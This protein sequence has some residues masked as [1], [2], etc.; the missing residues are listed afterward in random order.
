[1]PPAP[2][3]TRPFP[4]SRPNKT[5]WARPTPSR[6]WATL[7]RHLGNLDAAR[8]H[9]DAALPLYQGRT[10]PPRAPANTLQSLGELESHLGNLDAARAHYDAA[11]PLY[12]RPNVPGAWAR[13]TSSRS[14]GD[15][16]S[17]PRQ[18]RCRPRPLRRGSSPLCKA[19]QYRLGTG[20]HP[21][22]SGRPGAPPRQRR[23]RPRHPL[24][25]RPF[26]SSRPNNPAWARPPPRPR[27]WATWRAA[28]ATSRPPG[29]PASSAAL[30]LFHPPQ[31]RLRTANTL[32]SLRHLQRHLRNVHAAR[33][34]YYAALPLS[35]PNT[36]A[37]AP[38]TPSRVW[39]T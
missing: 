29:T 6:V 21:P 16:E 19:E 11:L 24:L 7:E 18:H 28:S 26:P 22:E 23:C 34:H 36:S 15:L 5:T 39:A 13:P 14:L 9:Y 38:P 10:S 1:M 17:P 12:A 35:K 37:W 20:H 2:T 33:P 31:S 4:S 8:A 3:T 25:T 32:K 27:V 30:P